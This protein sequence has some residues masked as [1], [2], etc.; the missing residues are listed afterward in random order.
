MTLA[1]LAKQ[2]FTGESILNDYAV[3]IQEDRITDI[4]PASDLPVD[5]AR[6]TYPNSLLAPG[7][8]DTQVNGGGGVLF[9]DDTSVKGINAIAK[10]HRQ[11]GTTGLLPT[12]I[13]GKPDKFSQAIT[14]VKQA[15]LQKVPGVLGVHLEGPYLNNH[16]KGVHNADQFRQPSQLD[17]Q[18]MTMANPGKVMITL[19]PEVVGNEVIQKLK[20]Q[21]IIVSAGHTAATYEQ[22][23]SALTAGVT[24]FTHLFNA[25]TPLQSRA[26]GVVG[27]ALLNPDS[28]CGIIVDGHHVHYAS[29]QLA[30]KTKPKGKVILVTDAMPV[31]G[32]SQ[33]SFVLDGRTIKHTDDRLETDDGTLAGSDLD[34]SKAVRNCVNHMDITLEEAL[35]MASAY[36]AEFLGLGDT[37]G[38]IQP[39]HTASLV[40]LN[41]QLVV[42]KTWIDGIAADHNTPT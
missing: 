30:L 8:I 14:A 31:T 36:P 27:A 25:M 16:R 12:L 6:Q 23:K 39:G 10:A 9:N 38:Y 33:D 1:L 13:T 11:F 32:S 21:G 5:I 40:L 18:A 3:I 22:I 24:G 17:I 2:L 37:L 19:A 34:M 4:M 26:P 15:I 41:Q 29:L 42:E 35:R 7:F 20:A 28:W